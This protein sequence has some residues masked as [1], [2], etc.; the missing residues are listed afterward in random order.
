MDH[1]RTDGQFQ[2]KIKWLG[3][4]DEIWESIEFV[5][6]DVHILMQHYLKNYHM[7]EAWKTKYSS[8]TAFQDEPKAYLT[9]LFLR[10]V[11][12]LEF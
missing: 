12:F 7:D 1:R 3:L 2:I 5:K 9:F 11:E 4:E 8:L 6:P 10:T